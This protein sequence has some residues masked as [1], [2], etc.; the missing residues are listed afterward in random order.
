MTR[1]HTVL[2]KAALPLVIS[3]CSG[4]RLETVSPPPQPSESFSVDDYVREEAVRLDWWKDLGDPRLD[5]LVEEALQ[6][7]ADLRAAG[8]NLKAAQALLSEARSQRLPSGGLSTGL[9]V[10]RTPGASLQL[11]TI[12][13][14]A[15][16]PTQTLADV[17]GSL[18]WELDLAGRIDALADA[19]EADA[20]KALWLTRAAQASVAANVVRAWFD[21]GAADERGAVAGEQRELLAGI[22]ISLD[23]AARIGGIRDDEARKV[24]IALADIDSQVEQANLERRNALRRLSTLRAISAPEALQGPGPRI[25]DKLPVP[26]FVRAPRPEQVLRQRPDVAIAELDLVRANAEIRMARADLY[27]RISFGGSVGLTAQPN[28]LG[29]AGAL[30]F[31]IGPSIRWGLFDMDRTRARIR[32]AGHKALSAGARWEAVTLLALEETDRA[33]DSY[34]TAR[35]T[36]IRLE[37]AEAETQRLVKSA[38]ERVRAGLTSKVELARIQNEA[39]INRSALDAAKHTARSVWVECQIALGAGWQ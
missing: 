14:P 26:Q 34:A 17:G 28:A 27:P 16:L 4:P 37:S 2:L 36:I 30:R 6:R 3:A 13:G 21:L 33:L 20:E 35:R 1:L 24:R 12:G 5:A 18:S 15:V 19:T 39:L 32:A 22:V 11:E 10:N 23:Q 29:D 9:E 7:N 38:T 25:V 8:A 31:G